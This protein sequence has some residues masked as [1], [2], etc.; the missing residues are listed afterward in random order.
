MA[1]RQTIQSL[2]PRV[3][4]LGE[5]LNG[6]APEGEGGEE[7]KRRVSNGNPFVP[8]SVPS[9]TLKLAGKLENILRE[10]T[11]LEQRGKITRFLDGTKDADKL[12]GVV[13]DI[14]DAMMDYQV[15]PEI[16]YPDSLDR[17][18]STSDVSTTR[19]LR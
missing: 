3:E 18:T 7:E 12:S 4:R 17:L 16:L 1:C 19:H 14:R 2:I 9:V 5:S 6:P 15:C 13:E 11:P 8:E 10:L